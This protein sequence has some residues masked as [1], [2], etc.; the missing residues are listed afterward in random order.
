MC[1]ICLGV[2]LVSEISRRS[3]HEIEVIFVCERSGYVCVTG[4]GVI[5]GD[6][7]CRKLKITRKKPNSLSVRKNRLI[8]VMS[9]YFDTGC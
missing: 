1:V 9:M 6:I 2:Y 5:Y 7:D 8:R 4:T 3:E